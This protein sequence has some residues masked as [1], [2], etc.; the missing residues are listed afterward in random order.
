MH[1]RTKLKD[2]RAAAKL[3]QAQLAKKVGV[4]Q[5]HYRRWEAGELPVPEHQLAVL[6]KALKV[7]PERLLAAPLKLVERPKRTDDDTYCGE[8]TVHFKGGGKPL[9]LQVSNQQARQV[10]ARMQSDDFFISFDTM[11]NQRVA[12]RL[13]AI[14]DLYISDEIADTY[15]PADDTEDYASVPDNDLRAEDWPLLWRYDASD[16]DMTDEEHD[17]IQALLD[18]AEELEKGAHDRLRKV[19]TQ[20]TYQLSNGVSRSISAGMLGGD[21]L[22]LYQSVEGL[23]V[24]GDIWPEEGGQNFVVIALSDGEQ[25]AFVN[26]GALDY[27]IV[28]KHMHDIGF[29]EAAEGERAAD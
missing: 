27:L 6:A 2:L 26:P 25:T 7:E 22:R 12:L 16:D 9:L 1:K 11:N 24:S 8:V 28:P 5:P 29:E 21:E 23:T 19:A 13:A 20:I 17:H 10:Y 4:S 18:R 3:T 15:G 14:A